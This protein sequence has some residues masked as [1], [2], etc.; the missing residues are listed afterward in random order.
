MFYIFYKRKAKCL[1]V[2]KNVMTTFV[3]Y[4]FNFYN[5]CLKICFIQNVTI[6]NHNFYFVNLFYLLNKMNKI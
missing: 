1:N 2:L 4:Y 5:K 6:F 3:F